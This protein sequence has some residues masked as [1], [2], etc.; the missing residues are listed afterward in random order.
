[1]QKTCFFSLQLVTPYPFVSKTLREVG[2]PV[3]EKRNTH[4][5][6]AILQ[7]EGIGYEDLNEL[8]RNPEDLEFTIGKI[9]ATYFFILC[10]YF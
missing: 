10:F 3:S 5:C 2:K 6:G 1:M 8:M 4:C 7:N 9:F